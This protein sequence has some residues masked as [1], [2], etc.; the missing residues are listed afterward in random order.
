M[1]LDERST[2]LDGWNVLYYGKTWTIKI[3]DRKNNKSIENRFNIARF[4]RNWRS[5]L[6][7]NDF[8]AR[9]TQTNKQTS[10]KSIRDGVAGHGSLRIYRRT[11]RQEDSL[12]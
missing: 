12:K 10:K 4:S 9:V 3:N 11:E 1:N 6:N 8:Q 2:F 7:V 5:I